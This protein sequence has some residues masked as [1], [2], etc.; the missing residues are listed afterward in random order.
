MLQSLP[1]VEI[2]IT[3]RAPQ[4]AVARFVRPSLMLMKPMDT[5]QIVWKTPNHGVK[6]GMTQIVFCSMVTFSIKG[7]RI[8]IIITI[9]NY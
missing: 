7:N 6:R 9:N 4:I 3:Y 1:S 8:V 5:F 2:R